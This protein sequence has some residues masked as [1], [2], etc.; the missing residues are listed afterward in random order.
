MEYKKILEEY[1]TKI[2]YPEYGEWCIETIKKKI[3]ETEIEDKI[4]FI[5][6]VFNPQDD[7]YLE[8]FEYTPE[9]ILG[10]INANR[11]YNQNLYYWLQEYFSEKYRDLYYSL[12]Q[13]LDN[14]DAVTDLITNADV[15]DFE[16]FEKALEEIGIEKLKS[17]ILKKFS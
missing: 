11:Y 6:R 14:T 12:N 2:V 16:M 10:R 8:Y 3:E 4:E 5:N 15:L 1:S 7:Y 13:T 9:F 17:I